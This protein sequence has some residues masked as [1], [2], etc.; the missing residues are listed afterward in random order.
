LQSL[1]SQLE[2][3]ARKELRDELPSDDEFELIRGYGAQ[4]EHFWQEVYKSEADGTYFTSA[5]FP[6]AVVADVATDPN[7]SVLEVGT[8]SV[9]EVYVVVSVEGSL[10][11]ATG[12]V[13]SFYQFEQPIDQRLT[14][15]QWRQM[16]G[17]EVCDDGMYHT[18]NAKSP[19]WW[20][21]DFSLTWDMLYA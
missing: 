17:I 18:E 4:I 20:T 11:L 19:E 15:S 5:E 1:A 12:A 2:T 8:G 10:R 14:D 21:D 3:I 9:S 16:M 7:G 6:A 13:Y